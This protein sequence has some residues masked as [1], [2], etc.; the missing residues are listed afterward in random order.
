MWYQHTFFLNIIKTNEEKINKANNHFNYWVLFT[1]IFKLYTNNVKNKIKTNGLKNK[2]K[3]KTL[4]TL[5]FHDWDFLKVHIW[6]TWYIIY[7]CFELQRKKEKH[8]KQLKRKQQTNTIRWRYLDRSDFC[9]F[10]VR[11]KMNLFDKIDLKKK[12]DWHH[13]LRSSV[14]Y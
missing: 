10:L 6:C 8:L 5:N 14:T 3:K 7:Y 1:L 2:N 11:W 9:V 12:I 13:Q 4:N